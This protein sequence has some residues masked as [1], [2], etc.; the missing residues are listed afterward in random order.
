MSQQSRLALISV[1]DK[2]GILEFATELTQ[3]GFK[4]LSTG[5]TAQVLRDH[6]IDVFDVA[7]YADSP[8]IMDGRVKTLHPKIHGGILMDRDNEKHV[9]EA[10]NHRILPIDLVVVNLYQF[11]Q[12]AVG[13]QLSLEDAINFVDIGGPTML[14]AAAKNY[15]YSLPVIDPRDYKQ[16][17]QELKKGQLSRELRITSAAKVFQHISEYDQ[18]IADYFKKDLH[19]QESTQKLNLELRSPL[20]YGENPHQAAEF[21]TY[22]DA[23]SGLQD[24]RVIQ[25]KE[26][27]YNNYLDLDAATA[28]VRDLNPMMSVA[29]I[30]HTN[31]CGAAASS[32]G[33]LLDV[34]KRALAADSKS[35]FG[36]IVACNQEI[37][38]ET[39]RAMSQI[40]LEC[41]AAP[42]ISEE[43][44]KIF[45]EK[46]NLRILK[47]PFLKE[48]F[49]NGESK[50]IRSVQG[51]L[52]I[53]DSDTKQSPPSSWT[54]VT[55]QK[56]S[57]D[58]ENDLA[59][60]WTICKH[61]KS[62]AIVFAKD[63]ATVAIGAGQMSRIDATKFA[64]SKAEDENKSLKGC[65]LASDAFFPFRDNIDYIA[66]L[67]VR[68]VI[69]PGGSK[70]DQE[71]IDACNE[72][73]IPMV[74]TGSRHFRH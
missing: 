39:A 33:T 65:V 20:R 38:A 27:S 44:L 1:T 61:V 15:L 19:D 8:E 31:P 17:I 26:L 40:F 5:G 64:S 73:C 32:S 29:I 43:A 12:K 24:C 69:Q 52:L 53:Q 50:S 34:F 59:F 60:A 70:R 66:P 67:G 2:T 42:S 6:S 22:P 71:S 46:K 58:E 63:L 62:N 7:E 74:F 13:S 55:E 56:L 45:Q 9:K 36:G 4:I 10:N 49:S 18:L 51:G 37:D 11:A 28:I 16:I 23:S 35:A 48:A 68:A 25:G 54:T 21:Y 41:I 47:A 3:L 57:S 30:K 72:H 14:R